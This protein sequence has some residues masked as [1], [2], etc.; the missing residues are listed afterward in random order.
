MFD[1][2]ES[3]IVMD[4]EVMVR[5]DLHIGGHGESAPGELDMGVLKD[6]E[7]KPIIPGSSLKGVLR[8]E[9][10]KLLKGLWKKTC[11]PDNDNLC[12]AGK[13]CTVCLLFGG[14]EYAGSI[15]IRDAVTD[16]R[17]TLVRDG[18]KIER[19]S[20]KAARGAFYQLEV[21]PRGM[22]FKGRITIENPK[23]K[24]EGEEKEYDYAKLGALLGTI[25][26]FNATSKSLGGGISRGFGEV[27]VVPKEIREVTADDYLKGNYK[28][29]EIA[30]LDD[31]ENLE[32]RL[33]EGELPMSPF[34]K[35]NE[36]IEDWKGYVNKLENKN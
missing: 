31:I 28:G 27:L 22:V 29:K 11:T 18:V 2:L 14:R 19:S 33:E 21:V 24:I 4:Y 7:E 12:P 5:S 17:K 10:E 3:R 25:R 36:F 26:F 35:M 34:D 15:R 30:K 23:L 6:A 13:E 16:T 32:E 9:M 8:S 20:R 1:V